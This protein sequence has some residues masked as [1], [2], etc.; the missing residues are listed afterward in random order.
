M[1]GSIEENSKDEEVHF[2]SAF[3]INQ[4]NVALLFERID[5]DGS[6]NFKIDNE[7]KFG[8]EWKIL[9]NSKKDYY[10]KTSKILLKDL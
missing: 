1:R 4:M 10:K 2:L 9:L 7:E 6:E 5:T 3:D 8:D